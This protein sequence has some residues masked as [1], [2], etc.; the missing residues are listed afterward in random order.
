[1]NILLSL[2]LVSW[3]SAALPVVVGFVVVLIGRAQ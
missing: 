1:M 2:A 3:A